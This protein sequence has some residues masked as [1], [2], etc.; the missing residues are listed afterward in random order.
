[1]NAVITACKSSSMCQQSQYT[2]DF[3]AP[4]RQESGGF[5][6]G[7]CGGPHVFQNNVVS[8]EFL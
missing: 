8:K 7:E 2:A 1:M 6:S 5:R 4:H 3:A